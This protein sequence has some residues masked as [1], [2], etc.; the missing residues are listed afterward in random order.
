[1]PD[2]C[3]VVAQLFYSMLSSSRNGPT[4]GDCS[5]DM[6]AAVTTVPNPAPQSVRDQSSC[7]PGYFDLRALATY[8]S[9]S[10]RWLRSRLVDKFS[11]L[12]HHRVE[13]KILVKREDF[14]AWMQ[15]FRKADAPAGL[16]LLVDDV[17]SS[18]LT[19]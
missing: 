15:H 11:P 19:K 13:G 3:G 9:C 14:D 6:K 1:M 4:Q 8:S 5:A 18:L 16:D 17:L 2:A 10:V 12:P 7:W